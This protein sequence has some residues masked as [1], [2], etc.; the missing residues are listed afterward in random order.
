[1]AGVASGFTIRLDRGGTATAR[2]LLLATGAADE[3]PDIPGAGE[4]WGRDFLHCPYCH[5]WEIRDRPIGVLGTGAGSVDHAQLLRQWS[6]DVLFFAHSSPITTGERRTLRARGIQVVDG[7][8]AQLSLRDGRLDAVELTD[9][10]T[11]PRAALFMRPALR[12]RNE[13]LIAS[14]GCAVD[15]GGF[16][17]VDTSG[18][19]SVPGVWAAGNVANPRAQ[20]ITAAGEG[21]AAAIAINAYLVEEDV[22]GALEPVA[23]QG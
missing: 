6:D 15:E 8:V 18:R 2:T 21:S 16:V 7:L 20:V 19:T 9:G 23:A 3:L 4:L 17:R 11:V 5:G 12:P 10:R 13:D 1:V 22:R 14:L